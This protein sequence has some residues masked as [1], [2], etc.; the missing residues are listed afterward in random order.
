MVSVMTRAPVKSMLN[1]SKR[2]LST[3]LAALVL[4]VVLLVFLPVVLFSIFGVVL[5]GETRYT[6]VEV[7]RAGSILRNEIAQFDQQLHAVS[8]RDDIYALVQRKNQAEIGR[9]FPDVFFASG[10]IHFLILLDASAVPVFTHAFDPQDQTGQP[11]PFLIPQLLHSFPNLARFADLPDGSMGLACWLDRPVLLASRPIL[12][13]LESGPAR[14]MLIAGRYLGQNELGAISLLTQRKVVIFCRSQAAASIPAFA[15][16]GESSGQVSVQMLDNSTSQGYQYLSDLN[17]QPTLLLRVDNPRDLYRQGVLTA[18]IISGALLVLGL[19][20]FNVTFNVTQNIIR[21]RL[22]G[23][24]K[25]EWFQMVV[26]QSR[27]A[28]FK[29]DA[30]L[31]ILQINPAARELLGAHPGQILVA[32]LQSLLVIEPALDE[33]NLLNLCAAR[34]PQE[35]HCI[36]QDGVHLDLEI[37]ASRIENDPIPAFSLMIHDFTAR[38]K[39]E[40]ALKET[41]ATLIE[42]HEALQMSTEALQTSEERYMLAAQGSHDGLWDLNLKTGKIYYSSRWKEM[43]GFSDEEL[44]PDPEEWYSRVHP[45]DLLQL[46]TELSQHLQKHTQHFECEYRIMPK[47]GSYRWMLARGLAVWDPAGYA[48]RIAG[49]QT[50]IT[51]RKELEEQ[52]RYDAFHDGLTGV[53]NRNLL[54]DHLKH[55]NDRKKSNPDLIFA[56]FFLDLD[57]FKKVN[58]TLGHQAGDQLL[59]ETA[60]RLQNS[61]LS[62]D[63]ISRLTGVETLAR[64]AGDEYVLLIEDFHSIGDVQKV[65]DRVA[66]VLSAPYHIAGREVSLS[67]SIGYVIPDQPYEQV[68]DII[69][70]ADIAMYQ[71]KKRGTGQAILFQSEMYRKTLGHMQLE[72][73]LRQAVERREFE[74]FYQ[75]IYTLADD[76]M[77]GME[78]LV[79]WNHPERGL[80]APAEFIQVAEDT[81][82]IVPIGYF[83]LR[84]SCCMMQLWRQDYPTMEELFVSV[85]LSAQQVMSSSMAENIRFILAATGFDPQ[86]L[87]LEV[88]ESMLLESNEMVIRQ[89]KEL[90]QL[91]IRIEID[92][93]GTGYSSLSY[94][95]HLPI[96]GFKIDRS[97]IRD[98]QAEGRQIVKTLADLGHSMGL[99]EVAEGV[100]TTQQ[101]DYLKTV[102]CDYIQGYLMS[103]PVSAQAMTKLFTRVDSNG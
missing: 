44:S 64:I 37:S 68:E 7:S 70:D 72:N 102:S 80:L 98:I 1:Q 48:H 86:R 43:L 87:W 34:T 73:E 49:S 51:E 74:V 62:I 59:V 36:R 8:S 88:T 31:R 20:L 22:T 28:I 66:K 99:T 16:A 58:D 63:F 41:A 32:G 78:A 10:N 92:D 2:R 76:R 9:L 11:L 67:A 90:R 54:I 26:D 69:R 33:A 27:D 4:L 93:F 96:D 6:Q 57:R 89:L 45:N 77:V 71:A 30:D 35:F 101:K 97:F 46:R 60:Q 82:L 40:I 21:A 56:L 38:K 5:N 39:A 65:A 12:T 13:S 18:W 91:G 94:L 24:H 84:E 95:Q 79:R 103:R 52:L 29:V 19:I 23:Q 42:R 3:S 75:P 100:E 14:G 85:N 47:V 81:G 17:G 61:L 50:D 15:A 55:V 53:A 25:L 83:V